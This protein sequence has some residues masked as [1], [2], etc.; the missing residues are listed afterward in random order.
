WLYDAL[1]KLQVGVAVPVLPLGE[2]GWSVVENDSAP[3][4]FG[5]SEPIPGSPVDLALAGDVAVVVSTA[6]DGGVVLRAIPPAGG[7]RVAPVLGGFGAGTLL[8]APDGTPLVGAV[9]PRFNGPDAA[10][11]GQVQIL[12]F[13]GNPSVAEGLGGRSSSLKRP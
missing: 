6:D 12:P 7:E 2:S 9:M 3:G 13:T 11:A 10:D 8:L 5:L 1:T 4:G